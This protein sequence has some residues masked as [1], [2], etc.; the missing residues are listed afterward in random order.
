MSRRLACGSLV[1]LDQR[2]QPLPV[3]GS[4]VP[5]RRSSGAAVEQALGDF[6]ERVQ[7][8]A[9]QEHRLGV[10]A[11]DGQEF[12]G[13][14][15]DA[16]RQHHELAER[17]DLGRV[18]VSA[19]ASAT[20]TVSADLEQVGRLPVDA[21]SAWP[22]SVSDLLLGEH[23]AGVLLRPV[24]QR[25][26][27]V[28]LD[29]CTGRRRRRRRLQAAHVAGQHLGAFLHLGERPACCR[30]SPATPTW[31]AAATASAPGRWRR[32][33]SSR[34]AP[35]KNEYSARPIRPIRPRASSASRIR[36]CSPTGRCADHRQ[37]GGERRGA[38]VGA[39]QA[40][41]G[42]VG[43]LGG[44]GRG[45]D[46]SAGRREAGGA[47]LGVERRGGSMSTS[48][49]ARSGG[50]IGRLPTSLGSKWSA[51]ATSPSNGSESAGALF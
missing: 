41:L 39:L 33:G 21:R 19:A 50:A 12:V 2:R 10:D 5:G 34:R 26:D 17:R 7:V 43:D 23:D 13:R 20:D 46:R 27:H 14:L 8:L 48:G 11:F 44:H 25:H 16:L 29:S 38:A 6:V 40:G 9:E 31:R 49:R 15:A 4:R 18:D 37:A 51:T 35:A 36:C 32:P 1:E 3:C 22:T 28:E 24:D 30:P 45:D 47:G 42:E